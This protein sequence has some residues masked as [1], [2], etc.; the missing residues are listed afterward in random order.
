MSDLAL[1]ASRRPG[2]TS[3]SAAEH[4][5]PA[6]ADYAAK[7]LTTPEKYA[8]MYRASMEDPAK[9]WSQHAKRLQWTRPFTRVKDVNWDISKTR[10]PE[11]LHIRWFEHGE[12][13]V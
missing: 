3:M 7:A 10:D 8:E 12:L 1:R 9:F 2:R 13:N 5:Y 4:V 11:D 6:P